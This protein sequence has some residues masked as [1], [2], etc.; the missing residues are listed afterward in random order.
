MH[1]RCFQ[2]KIVQKQNK[3]VL[4]IRG[5]EKK[6][7]KESSWEN[8]E[9]KSRES[10]ETIPKCVPVSSGIFFFLFW[11]THQNNLKNHWMVKVVIKWNAFV[12]VL[13]VLYAISFYACMN[14]E[15]HENSLRF[16]NRCCFHIQISFLHSFSVFFFQFMVI[17][18]FNCCFFFSWSRKALRCFEDNF[19]VVIPKH[20]VENFS[21]ENLKDE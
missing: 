13:L 9:S 10:H 5:R 18:S 3:K 16:H 1:A 17:Y 21:N 7:I 8:I 19:F 6:N 4:K 2:K 12:E 15:H 14:C 20:N 11:I